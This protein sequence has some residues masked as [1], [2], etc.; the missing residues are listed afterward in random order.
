MD[1]SQKKKKK[2]RKK[3]I[4]NTQD[5]VHKLKRLNKVKCPSEDTSV[6]L[7]REKKAITNGEEGRDLEG[8][9][10]K[11]GGRVEGNLIWYWVREKN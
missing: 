11:V 7:G 2:K 10:D 5:T 4:Q 3:T 1:I 6:P 9:V 8:T